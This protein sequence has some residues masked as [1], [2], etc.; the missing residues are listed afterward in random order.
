MRLENKVALI[1]GASSGVGAAVALDLAKRGVKVVINF[2]NNEHGAK[3]TL[4]QV[5][6]AGS[7]GAIFQADVSNNQECCELVN[8]VVKEF[9]RL[10]VVINN[11]GTTSFVPHNELDQLSDE[12]WR[13]TLNTNLLGPFY[14]SRAAT[15]FLEQ[16]GGGEIV[17]T[18]SIA[19][20]TTHGSSIA[21]CASKAGLNSLTKTLAKTLGSKNIRVNAVCP[22]LIDGA[23]SEQGWG[24]HWQT[25]KDMTLQASAIHHISTPQDVAA[26]IV[27][28]ITGPD[29]M[30]GQIISLDSGL[31]L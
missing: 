19:G 27:H 20:L 22:G 4:D 18:S 13:S 1:T 9:G 29:N 23:W 7:V 30:T 11:A 31:T 10:D 14:I 3:Q 12:I 8:F 15:P 2:A 26:S 24:E 17:M 25:A 6:Q 21:Y 28:I 5:Q 16:Q